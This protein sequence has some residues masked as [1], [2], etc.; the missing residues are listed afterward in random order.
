[1]PPHNERDAY[2]RGCAARF[3]RDLES[4][5]TRDPL[6]WYNFFPYWRESSPSKDKPSASAALCPSS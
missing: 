6:Q 2:L 5:V 1:M 4:V 3:A